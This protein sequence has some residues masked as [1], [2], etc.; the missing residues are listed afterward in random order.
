MPRRDGPRGV[1]V[2]AHM[3]DF[4]ETACV[5]AVVFEVLRQCG[6]VRHGGAQRAT[7]FK[8]VC[9]GR[10]APAEHGDARGRAQRLLHIAALEDHAALRQCIEVRRLHRRVAIA[11][12]LRAHVVAGDE[13][14]IGPLCGQ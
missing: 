13:E 5:V 14:D 3:V 12:E 10:I 11:A 2:D 6:D 9:S 4:A 7:D 8:D 1:V